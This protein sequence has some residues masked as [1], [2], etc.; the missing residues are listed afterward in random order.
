MTMTVSRLHETVLLAFLLNR[1]LDLYSSTAENG[2]QL[3]Q[4]SP[5]EV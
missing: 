1:P 4:E 2:Q 3:T 5:G